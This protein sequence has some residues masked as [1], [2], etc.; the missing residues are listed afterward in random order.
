MLSDPGMPM[1][2]VTYEL[3]KVTLPTTNSRSSKKRAPAQC[4]EDHGFDSCQGL[5][6]FLCPT[7]VS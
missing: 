4:S 6:F 3:S 2:T 7:L 5:K 1:T